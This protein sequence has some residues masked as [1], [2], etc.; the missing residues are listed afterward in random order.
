MHFEYVKALEFSST[1][2][3]HVNT[4]LVHRLNAHDER[5]QKKGLLF[6]KTVK[7]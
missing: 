4:F 7:L 3:L 1:E 2:H 5:Y 6:S